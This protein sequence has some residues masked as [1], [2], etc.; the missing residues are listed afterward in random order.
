MRRAITIAAPCSL[1]TVRT[2]RF[3]P[4]QRF[5]IIAMPLFVVFGPE[6]LRLAEPE[7]CDCAVLRVP[8]KR[9]SCG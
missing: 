1:E 7:S 4:D 8:A 2:P 3:A 5:A 9:C 6:L